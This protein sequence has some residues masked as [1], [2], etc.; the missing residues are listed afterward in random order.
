M[1]MN[2]PSPLFLPTMEDK[3]TK[4]KGQVS[5]DKK[6]L[7]L[8]VVLGLIGMISYCFKADEVFPAASI[9]LRLGQSK[10]QAIAKNWAQEA[11]YIKENPKVSTVFDYDNESKTFL[12]YE[13]GSKE[14]NNLMRGDL[15][16]WYWAT[17]MCEPL[18]MEQFLCQVSP[19]GKLVAFNRQL[20]N[21]YALPSI[22]HDEAFALAKTFVETKVGIPL[23]KF[24]RIKHGTTS[25]V[26][27]SDHFF[28][29]ENKQDAYAGAHLRIDVNVS[30]NQITSFDNYL[31]VPEAWE[32]KF[33]KLR[34]YNELLTDLA[35]VFLSMLN[36]ATVF[37]FLWAFSG[38]LIRWRFAV[39]AGLFVS[40]VSLGESLNSLP[41]AIHS[42][43]TTIA[44]DAFLTD[45]YVNTLTSAAT[46]FLQSTVL[47]GAAEALYRLSFPKAIALEHLF[48]KASLAVRQTFRGLVAGHG[49][50]GI[51][52]GWVVFY[53]LFGRG[54]GFWSPLDVQNAETLSSY[55]PSFSAAYI[56]VWA[57]FT[58]EFLY[59][60]LGTTILTKVFKNFWVANILQAAAWAFMHSNYPQEPPYARGL[61]LT[62]VGFTYGLI[63]KYF[64]IL[65]CLISHYIFDTFL[66]VVP[67]LSSSLPA[68]KAQAVIVVVPF[69]IA[70]AVS[71]YLLIKAA[72]EGKDVEPDNFLNAAIEK[73]EQSVI[74]NE[75][76]P[77]SSFNY[78]P[79]KRGTRIVL[80]A[81]LALFTLIQFSFYPIQI[82]SGSKLSISRDEAIVIA[83]DYLTKKNLDITGRSIVA[84]VG[85]DI[86]G[87]EMQ[88][89]MEKIKF[90]KTLDL[91]RSVY[92]GLLW[93]VRFFR[94]LDPQVYLVSI[95]GQGDPVSFSVALDEDAEGQKLTREQ[96]QNLSEKYLK[97]EQREYL[98]LTQL[99]VFD[100][101]RS[102]RNDY[103]LRYKSEKLSLPDAEFR[104]NVSCLGNLVC[105]FTRNWQLPDKWLFEKARRT[106]KDQVSQYLAIGLNLITLV[107]VIWWLKGLAA[108]G[109]IHWR[110]AILLSVP[111][112]LTLIPQ[113]L[114]DLP[115]LFLV[116]DTSNPVDTFLT[117]QF[118]RQILTYISWLA[119]TC[120][121]AAFS[122][123]AFRILSPHSP[124]NTIIKATISQKEDDRPGNQ[125]DL[126]ID[127]ILVGYTFGIGWQAMDVLRV[128]LQTLFSPSVMI[129]PLDAVTKLA[130]VISPSIETI[131]DAFITGTFTALTAA[132]LAG[133]YAKYVDKR[134][135][136]FIASLAIA[137]ALNVSYRYYQDIVIGTL[138]YFLGAIVLWLLIARFAKTNALAYFLLGASYVMSYALRLLIGYSPG[139][140]ANDIAIIALI[141][142]SPVIYLMLLK[143]KRKRSN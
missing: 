18:Q 64:G 97:S 127:A 128:Y 42:Y 22:S 142:L 19:S 89:A 45:Y 108:T 41:R 118:V 103:S 38:G 109:P 55:V 136:Y 61:E 13:L 88:Y 8:L 112:V 125:K 82:G 93:R 5:H 75:I 78:Q 134:S 12:E 29:W 69:A 121:T 20:P 14:A 94:P 47:A 87:H 44:Y 106:T 58:E 71:A 115:E 84:W 139:L 62:V 1:N 91:S 37:I 74:L 26:K 119:V 10:V 21:D 135:H 120:A 57:A 96:A 30:G 126:W 33:S 54:L 141:L 130:G 48:T 76:L 122:L 2:L 73:K 114:N 100:S 104:V 133:L 86:N 98:P 137:L 80:F 25:Q 117:G 27:R 15:P 35:S 124:V 63:L 79:L 138:F 31:H 67:L 107:L 116:Y 28:T 113:S 72:K 49:L 143:V 99:D 92:K 51:H 101:A 111:I 102:K 66:G 60:I 56:G 7:F 50:F 140:F 24:T 53:Y 83:Q 68:L 129:A 4:N 131:T 65:P 110:P 81:L 6:W 90:Q 59:R 95:D 105:N 40:L 70:L 46:T 85:E 16:V 17:R 39:F 36:V 43:S 34:S 52:L 11:G 132:S 32:R 9:D 123:A 23:T 3:K 77:E